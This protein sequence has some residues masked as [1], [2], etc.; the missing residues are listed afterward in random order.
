MD[1]FALFICG[2]V[3]ALISG[4]GI[5]TSEVFLGYHNYLKKERLKHLQKAK[6]QLEQERR[7]L[8]EVKV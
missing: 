2:I 4:M 3:V 6:L 8:Q 7:F 5:I 1:N